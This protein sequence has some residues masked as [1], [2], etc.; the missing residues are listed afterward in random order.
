M[1]IK[2][3]DGTIKNCSN[4]TEQKIFRG[5][6]AA[7]W[8]CSFRLTDVMTSSD[9]DAV[10]VNDNVTEIT[11]ITDAIDNALSTT[12]TLTDYDKVS[13]AIIRHTNTGSQVEIQ[14]TKGV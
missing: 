1:K 10:L 7:G 3:K 12:F 2:F 5:G 11:F 6:T 14:L 9:V 13:S 8:I 4:P